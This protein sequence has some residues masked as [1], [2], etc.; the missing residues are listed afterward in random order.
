MFNNIE[1]LNCSVFELAVNFSDMLS[2]YTHKT[3][4]TL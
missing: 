2:I 3:W 1:I 4:W